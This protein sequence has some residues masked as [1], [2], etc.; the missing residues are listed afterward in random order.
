MTGVS[1]TTRKRSLRSPSLGPDFWVSRILLTL[2]LSNHKQMDTKYGIE[3]PNFT[4]QF[5]TLQ[6]LIDAV[7]ETGADPNWRLTCNGKPTPELLID[8]IQP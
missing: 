1:S 4:Q 6:E 8:L 3:D 7:I 2:A 5:D